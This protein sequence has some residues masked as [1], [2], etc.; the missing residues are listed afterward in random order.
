MPLWRGAQVKHRDFTFKPLLFI[1]LDTFAAA[2]FVLVMAENSKYRD[3]IV[4]N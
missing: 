2:F 1:T 4:L 3:D